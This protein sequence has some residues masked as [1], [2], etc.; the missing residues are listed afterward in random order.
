MARIRRRDLA[1]IF[2]RSFVVQGSWN[3]RK[4]LALGFCYA[5]LPICNRLYKSD[6]EKKIQFVRRHLEFFNVHP[7]FAGW[8]L[9]AVAKLEEQNLVQGWPDEK[10]IIVFK[11]RL[12]GILSAL[13]DKLFWS[14]V[15]PFAGLIGVITA[16]FANYLAIFLFLFLYNL[17]HLYFRFKGVIIGY[18]KG[19]DIVSNVS[20][21]RFEKYFKLLT[22]GGTVST[23]TLFSYFGTKIMVEKPVIPDGLIELFNYLF[24]ITLSILLFARQ[25]SVPRTMLIVAIAGLLVGSIL[26]LL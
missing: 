10:P 11:N 22:I 15:K 4:M 12:S 7:Y 9:G 8:C 25:K 26:T 23:G 18:I 24:A 21:R 13:G 6:Q 3:F 17:F 16:L 2:I 5:A 1:Q 14:L 20:F 19:F